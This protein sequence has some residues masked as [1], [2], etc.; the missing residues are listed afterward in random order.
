VRRHH[1]AVLAAHLTVRDQWLLE[2]LHEHKV[3][4]SHQILALAYT[5]VPQIIGA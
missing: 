3:L 5:C 2:M 4:T 1:L